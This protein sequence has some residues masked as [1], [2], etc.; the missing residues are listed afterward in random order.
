MDMLT[1]HNSWLN[2][3]FPTRE[4]GVGGSRVSHTDF[5]SARRDNDEQR[6]EF[7]MQ[8]MLVMESPT[9]EGTAS[10]GSKAEG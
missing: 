5:V 3:F 4:D 7:I 6:A 8:S 9:E 1:I 2:E 10:P